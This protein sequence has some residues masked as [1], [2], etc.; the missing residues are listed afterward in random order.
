MKPD[1]WYWHSIAKYV[2]EE[3][4]RMK[5]ETMLRTYAVRISADTWASAKYP[6]TDSTKYKADRYETKNRYAALE[7]LN[8]W[9]S[10]SLNAW[11]SPSAALREIRLVRILHNRSVW[12][13]PTLI[14][15]GDDNF[16]R[17]EWRWENERISIHI[18]TD[19]D[20]SE[21]L[22]TIHTIKGGEQISECGGEAIR[23]LKRLLDV[24]KPP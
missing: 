18:G 12:P 10:R 1:K 22:F 20:A 11:R 4:S 15:I 23:H 21:A 14:D 9:R 3:N 13:V 7:I 16:L 5:Q 17:L 2:F 19:P 6:N 8:A 24:K